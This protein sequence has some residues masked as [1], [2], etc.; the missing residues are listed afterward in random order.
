MI[1]AIFSIC[2]A[3]GEAI[4]SLIAGLVEI[5]SGFFVAAGE[6]LSILDLMLVLVVASAELIAWF[7]LWVVE[8]VLS[9]VKWRKPR[10]VA[11]P[12]YWRPSTKLKSKK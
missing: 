3:I 7:F 2:I 6:T 4:L 5:L 8:L 12:I 10:K 1:E 9:L 11:K